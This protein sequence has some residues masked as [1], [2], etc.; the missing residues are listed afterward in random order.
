M[1]REL[2]LDRGVVGERVRAVSH[3][4][5]RREVEHVHEQPRALDVREEVVA[6]PGAVAGALDQARDVGDDQ[7]A[8]APASR[9]S[10]PSTGESVVNG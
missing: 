7:L 1:R 5:L 10:T 3:R 4:E 2:A 8:F 9:S 6:E